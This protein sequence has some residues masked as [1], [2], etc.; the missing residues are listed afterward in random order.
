METAFL[1]SSDNRANPGV[2]REMSGAALEAF[3]NICKKWQLSEKE[4][5]GL[6]GWPARSTLYKWKKL[7][8]GALPYD[9]LIRISLIL[10]IYKALHILYP[11]EK[12]ANVWIKMPN[13]NPLF[14]GRSP[15]QVVIDQGIEGLYVV[16]RLLDARKG[17]WH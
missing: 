5:L 11:Q 13:I 17:G 1:T 4:E 14:N 10:G 16:R 3:F 15:L 7:E 2:R 12:I 9:T 6:L 8:S